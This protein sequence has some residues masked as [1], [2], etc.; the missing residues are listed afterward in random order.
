MADQHTKFCECCGQPKP[1][2]DDWAPA[3]D[4]AYTWGTYWEDDPIVHVDTG[5]VG[6]LARSFIYA[7]A[8]FGVIKKPEAA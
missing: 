8:Y 1:N 7:M 3:I 6:F 4:L 2:L 5:K